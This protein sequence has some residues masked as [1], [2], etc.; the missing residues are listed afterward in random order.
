MLSYPS[1]QTNFESGDWTV[2]A[3]LEHHAETA[4]SKIFLRWEDSDRQYSF[5][6]VNARTNAL[7]AGF[8][9]RGIV[10][11]DRVAILLPNCLE[12]VF[13]W[14][15]LS[16]LGAIEVPINTNYKGSFFE[17][18]V[19]IAGATTI[20]V[21][22]EFLDVVTASLPN[23]HSVKRVIVVTL[24]E[25]EDTPLG[26]HA[27]V[28]MLRYETL[29]IVGATANPPRIVLP[30]DI[31]AIMFTSGTTGP[32]KGVL[33][34]HAH[35]YMF[36][37]TNIATLRL[38]PD[39]IYYICLPMF[40][41]NA[42]LLSLYPSLI[43]GAGCAI[44]RKFSA[45][46]WIQQIH[47]TGATVTNLIGAMFPFILGQPAGPADRT[48]RLRATQSMP[49]NQ[50]VQDKFRERF[51][52]VNFCDSYGQTEI[53]VPM[54][55]PL[56]MSDKRP[57]NSVGLLVQDFYEARIVDPETDEDVS[58]GE[59]GELLIRHRVPWIIN[60][61]YFGM[62]DQ[63]VKTWQNLWYHTGDALRRDAQGWYYFVDRLKDT[64]RRRGENI[65][66]YEI[67]AQILQHP[68]VSDV[69]A[70]AVPATDGGGEDE[71]K[72]CIV[73]AENGRLAHAE[74][75]EWCKDR[76]PAFAVPRFIEFMDVLPRTPTEKVQKNLLRKAGITVT[77]WDR[78]AE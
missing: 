33:M 43:A 47:D 49:A 39:D 21:C 60:S 7:A 30:R 58:D 18:P 31:G 10:Q 22:R 17:H 13:T 73:L 40:H 75:I 67:E 61:G 5:A 55:V 28:D 11:G 42:Q 34:P 51:G 29:A 1:F 32:S 3:I 26:S 20:V 38:G 9:A 35:L 56:A 41:A 2:P 54:L 68:A 62:P 78:L 12:Y 19:N 15:A 46:R 59:I 36:A 16:K 50:E 64:I 44:F 45:S 65:S 72:L 48:H 37:Q 27:T 6:E 77:T 4:G 14:F 66:S 74:V 63:T 53:G 69:A 70:V 8:A 24:D 25:E 76:V 57:A 23:L 52:P 71:V